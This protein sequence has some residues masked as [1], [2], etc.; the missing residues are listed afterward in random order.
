MHLKVIGWNKAGQTKASLPVWNIPPCE[1]FV[2]PAATGKYFTRPSRWKQME[3]EG[4]AAASCLSGEGFINVPPFENHYQPGTQQQ[5]VGCF[6]T[7]KGYY[8]N[9]SHTQHEKVRL[10]KVMTNS[11]LFY[12]IWA[13]GA[14]TSSRRFKVKEED[15]F[16][17]SSAGMLTKLLNEVLHHFHH[18]EPPLKLF[19]ELSIKFSE[20]A[21]TLPASGSSLFKF[22]KLTSGRWR[23]KVPAFP[24]ELMDR[25]SRMYK[26]LNVK[27]A[28]ALSSPSCPWRS[29]SPRR[30]FKRWPPFLCI[31]L[32]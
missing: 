29:H 23:V 7:G 11:S 25:V 8:R 17:S 9:P 6:L 12:I 28:T 24:S 4:E 13:A 1:V 14:V 2:R 18:Q 22:E 27:M 20:S 31:Y 15:D 10:G 30:R 16:P 19:I 26:P 3:T 32:F 21:F 5:P